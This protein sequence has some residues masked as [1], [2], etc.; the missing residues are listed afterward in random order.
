MKSVSTEQELVQERDGQLVDE[1]P[2]PQRYNLGFL[3]IP[4]HCRYDPAT[5]FNFSLLLNIWFGFCST[6]TV[7]N[8]ESCD[9]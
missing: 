5:P 6:L 9:V 4:R 2:L 8:R 3:P 7:A 1:S